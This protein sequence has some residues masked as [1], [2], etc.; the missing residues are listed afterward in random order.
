MPNSMDTST[1]R[2]WTPEADLFQPSAVYEVV[3]LA[4]H[5]DWLESRSQGAGGSDAAA[6][7]GLSRFKTLQDLW[8]EKIQGRHADISSNPAVV[9]GNSCEGALRTLYQAKHLDQEVQYKPD[10]ILISK[11]VPWRRYSPDGLI[12]EP[13]TG[14]KGVLEIKTA[15]IRNAKKSAEWADGIPIEYYLQVLHGLLVTDFDFV[16]LTAELRYWDG[17]VQIVE[18]TYN[19]SEIESDLEEL[20]RTET[21]TWTAYFA[22]GI[23]P[24]LQI[25]V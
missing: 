18:R 4:T 21:E 7:C 6:L 17:R 24:P 3:E 22:T 9:Y 14:R 2:I 11:A 12:Y 13:G 25:R 5:E 23:M 19:R 10:T 20:D 8:S 16:T 15:Q 1:N